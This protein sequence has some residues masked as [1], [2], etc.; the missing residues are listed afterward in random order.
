MTLTEKLKAFLK[1][2][3]KL[4]NIASVSE[5]TICGIVF[6]AMPTLHPTTCG[7]INTKLK[8]GTK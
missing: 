5:C 4:M 8:T 1:K 6:V 7:I 3:G 2:K